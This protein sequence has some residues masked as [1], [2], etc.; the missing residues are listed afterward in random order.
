MKPGKIEEVTAYKTTNGMLF[1]NEDTAK[2]VQQALNK[3]KCIH[4]WVESWSYAG[5][6]KSDIVEA[7]VNNIDMLIKQLKELS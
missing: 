3:T 6:S 7:I 1:Q 2:D 4:N 5:I